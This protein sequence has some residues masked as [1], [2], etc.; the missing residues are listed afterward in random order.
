MAVCDYSKLVMVAEKLNFKISFGASEYQISSVVHLL[1]ETSIRQ[2]PGRLKQTIS[3][4]I[5]QD[6]RQGGQ[7]LTLKGQETSSGRE[8]WN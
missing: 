4:E 3:A 8:L 7:R 5:H 2:Y 1:F 6:G